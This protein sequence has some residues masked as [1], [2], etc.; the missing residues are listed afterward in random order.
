M[1]HLIESPEGVDNVI[2]QVQQ[3]LSDSVNWLDNIYGRAQTLI[4]L[5]GTKEHK[6]PSFVN[7]NA[8]Y[9]D[10]RPRENLGN[11]CFFT[12]A[13]PQEID[14]IERNYN[15]I[16]TP[17]SLIVWLKLENGENE[18]TYK[19]DILNLLNRKIRLTSGHL[20]VNKIF[21]DGENIYKGYSLK[22][23]D[24]QYLMKPFA[25]FRIEGFLNYKESCT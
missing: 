23:T 17:F 24:S 16:K 9:T 25:G 14:F 15:N 13:D 1:I 18:E 8:E 21:N 12:V 11:F 5:E 7:D 10:L 3:A 20:T 22:Q 4:S 6:Y 19:K 2:V